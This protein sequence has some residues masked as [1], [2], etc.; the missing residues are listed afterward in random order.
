[1]G[2]PFQPTPCRIVPRWGQKDLSPLRGTESTLQ[3][4]AGLVRATINE[5]MRINEG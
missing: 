4:Q 3:T 1:M 2:S 5:L